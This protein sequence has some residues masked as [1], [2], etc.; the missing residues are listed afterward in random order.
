MAVVPQL[1]VN[2]KPPARVFVLSFA[3]NV[4]VTFL[5]VSFFVVFFM[6][7]FLEVSTAIKVL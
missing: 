2:V 3:N 6:V 1:Q 5:S 4:T 7:L